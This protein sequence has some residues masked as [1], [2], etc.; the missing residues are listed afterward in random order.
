MPTAEPRSRQPL[1]QLSELLL[2]PLSGQPLVQ[3]SELPLG[4][5][6]ALTGFHRPSSKSSKTMRPS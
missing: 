2:G 1:V 4:P 5:L 6:S 3:L